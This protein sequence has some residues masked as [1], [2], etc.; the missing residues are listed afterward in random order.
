MLVKG[1]LQAPFAQAHKAT[2]GDKVKEEVE[3]AVRA[4]CCSMS[5]APG[6]TPSSAW[7][8]CAC[9]PAPMLPEG[10]CSNAHSYT[11]KVIC[12]MTTATGCAAAVFCSA[13]IAMRT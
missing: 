6:L 3:T 12:F 8:T 11:A 7:K 13:G 1:M 4:T 9:M 5:T 2:E 10:S